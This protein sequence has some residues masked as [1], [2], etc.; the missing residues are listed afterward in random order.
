MAV[1][2]EYK[3]PCCDGAIAFDSSL[4]KM[5]CPFCDT[6]FEMDTLATYDEELKSQGTDEMEWDAA[7][8]QQWEQDEASGLRI[9]VCESCGGE[10]VGDANLAATSC[11]FCDNPVVMKG[12]FAG[13]LKPDLVIPF[14]LDKKAAKDAL[15]RHY[16]GKRLLPKLFKDENH[17]DEIK[18]VYVPFWLFDTD[19]DAN[20]HYK[21]TRVRSWS[22]SNYVY[23]ETS[24]YHVARGGSLGFQ[25]VPVDGSSKMADDLMESIEPFDLSEAVDFKTAYLAG[26]MADK[27]DV[28]SDQ[29]IVRA[30]QRIKK[31]TEDAFAGTV[32]GYTTVIPVS[33]SI[34]LQ[35]GR[36]RYAL[37]PV[38]LLNTTWKDKKFTFAMN[39]QTGKMVGDLP[40]DKGLYFKWLLGLTG[41]IGLVA[42]GLG[43]LFGVM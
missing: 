35:N 30:N 1:L 9:Y 27:Y 41:I 6:E 18:G 42:F 12:Q 16:S 31:S 22:D 36:A 26:Y 33:S 3:C 29:S 28:D 14:K 25:A 40:M 10:I 15:K 43:W 39:G 32:K 4:Q 23:T 20:I 37:Y 8:G 11:P 13:D 24:Y 38:W 34:K 5:K 2:Q 21:A 17:I 7:P 19:A